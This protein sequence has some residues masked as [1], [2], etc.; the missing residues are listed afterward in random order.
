VPIG[1]KDYLVFT[2]VKD[3]KLFIRDMAVLRIA[4]SLIDVQMQGDDFQGEIKV[5]HKNKNRKEIKKA[6]S[7]LETLKE[8]ANSLNKASDLRTN[9]AIWGI[10]KKIFAYLVPISEKYNNI[11]MTH[12]ALYLASKRFNRPGV[13]DRLKIFSKT[14]GIKRITKILEENGIKSNGDEE[15]LA[16]ELLEKIKHI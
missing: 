6:E 12:L 10:S 13:L 4:I 11:S 15:K 8:I 2:K 9:E 1:H 14:W 7:Y 5:L 3:R 16:D